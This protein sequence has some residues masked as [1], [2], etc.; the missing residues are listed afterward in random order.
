MATLQITVTAQMKDAS[1]NVVGSTITATETYTGADYSCHQ[2]TV[3]DST[4][5]QQL[6]LGEL[7]SGPVRAVFKSDQDIT[8][9]V[10]GSS[11]VDARFIPAGLAHVWC[12]SAA[13]NEFYVTNASGSS[14]TVTVYWIEAT[15]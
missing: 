13:E 10:G 2:V 11:G 1:G 8:L 14:A 9:E 6:D 15:S 5:D 7:G 12:G 4:T 3:A